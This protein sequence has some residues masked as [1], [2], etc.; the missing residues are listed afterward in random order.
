MAE[1][2]RRG[3]AGGLLNLIGVS[4][5]RRQIRGCYGKVIWSWVTVSRLVWYLW[6]I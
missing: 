2:A 4:R 1:P 5:I 6:L 3:A